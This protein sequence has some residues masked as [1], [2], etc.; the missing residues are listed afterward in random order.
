VG[1]ANWGGGA[2]D[3]ETGIL[4]V[5]S[6][7]QAAVIRLVKPE[8]SS[9][10]D[11][12]YARG[13]NPNAELD[14]IPL[15]KPPYGHLTA[16]DLNKGEFVWRTAFGDD[17]KLRS[18]PALAGAKLPEKLGVSG[19]AGSMVTKGGLLFI[20]GGDA[21]FHAIDKATGADLWTFPLGRKTNGTPMT[22]ETSKGRQFVVIASGGGP[23]AVLTAFELPQ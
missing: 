16:I 21:S 17:E 6:S 7:N 20:G 9:E 5:R 14:G 23:N 4:Y 1:G 22:Y 10:V 2:F 19:N 3:P 13:G 12:D 15:L 8:H 18:H 11:A